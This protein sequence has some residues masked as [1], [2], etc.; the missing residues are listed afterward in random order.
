MGSQL[1][2]TLAFLCHL[3]SLLEQTSGVSLDSLGKIV[4]VLGKSFL[5]IYD[6]L[7]ELIHKGEGSPVPHVTRNVVFFSKKLTNI[8]AR[9]IELRIVVDIPMNLIRGSD[10]KVR[11]LLVECEVFQRDFGERSER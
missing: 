8:L 7:M 3:M 10:K 4:P 11:M 2:T 6:G 9:D 1:R 5:D